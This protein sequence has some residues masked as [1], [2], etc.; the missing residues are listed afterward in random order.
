MKYL[1]R[2]AYLGKDFYGSQKQKDHPTIQGVFED[3]LSMLY[4][5]PVKVTIASR[6]DRFVNALDFALTYS[7]EEEKV[8]VSR[9]LYYFRRTFSP[10][11]VIKG[12]QK[13]EENFSPRYDCIDKT[14]RYLIQTPD[15]INPL[16]APISFVLQRPIDLEKLKEAASLFEGEHDFAPFATLEE[17]G[18][19]TR[20]ILDR[21]SFS[22]EDGMI[23]LR[24][25]GKAFLRYQVRFMVGASLCYASGELSKE[26]LLASLNEGK[27][28]Q[29]VKAE[30]QGLLL[31]QIRYPEIE[32]IPYDFP[33]L[34]FNL[35]GNTL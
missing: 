19:K 4:R 7:V 12:I 9:V 34:H 33:G 21:T 2:L 35:K 8:D 28:W 5:E 20:L 23:S 3:A 24:F 31:E 15:K 10:S 29:K 25:T 18:E 32:E 17:E 11:I 1:V 27:P 26:D 13:V 30:P 22:L 14:Y 6:L 16:L